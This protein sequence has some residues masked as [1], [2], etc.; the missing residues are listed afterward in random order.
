MPANS[1]KSPWS[2]YRNAEGRVYWSHAIT[3]QSR[4]DKPD[5]L[6]SPFERALAK[7]EWKQYIHKDRPYFVHSLTKE[8]KWELP[9]ELRSLKK[10][11]EKEEK[12][13]EVK[14]S[15]RERGEDTWV[16]SAFLTENLTYLISLR[17]SPEPQSRSSSP[18]SLR[19]GSHNAL[20]RRR[21]TSPDHTAKPKETVTIPVGGFLKH[22][23]AEAAFIHLL[24]REGVN[25]NWTWD[26]TMR[27]I[28][29]DPL[30]KALDTL[31]EK[32]AAF[33][34]VSPPH[35]CL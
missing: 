20:A 31:A 9:P 29:M 28:I 7:T 27:K 21:S 18:D 13:E 10:R 24:E 35:S 8:T 3:K 11:V 14:R 22:E 12:Y 32:K 23:Q 2:E 25:E 6:K 30:Y 19:G 1:T 34:K 5:E 26:Q 4:W 15:A 17:P 16:S 33:E